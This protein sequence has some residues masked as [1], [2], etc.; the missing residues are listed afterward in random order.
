V[1]QS[2]PTFTLIQYIKILSLYNQTV[3]SRT[4][5][6]WS[7]STQ[8]QPAHLII[9]PGCNIYFKNRFVCDTKVNC[10]ITMNNA[11]IACMGLLCLI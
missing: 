5:N 8:K 11:S 4:G 3:S 1:N 7:K 10:I 2:N 9:S 6:V